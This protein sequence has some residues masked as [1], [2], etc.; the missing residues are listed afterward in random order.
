MKKL[1]NVF[2]VVLVLFLGACAQQDTI[3]TLTAVNDTIA[4]SARVAR[5]ALDQDRISTADACKVSVYGK[6]ARAAV[7][8]AYLAY[9]LGDPDGAEGHVR[10]AKD[11]LAGVSAEAT[12]QVERECN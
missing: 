6:L 9:G 11:I 3:S 4:S 12:A 8:E 1:F 2:P 7:D 5:I 10:A